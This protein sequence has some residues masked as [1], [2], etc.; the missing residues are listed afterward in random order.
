MSR[1]ADPEL[2]TTGPYQWIRH[3]IYSGILLGLAGT[4]IAVSA[5]WLIAV[6]ITGA[7]F[8]VSAVVE[9]RTMAKLFP[10][11]YPPYRR[12]TKM[13]IPFLL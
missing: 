6:A 9:E 10:A 5:Y 3:P 8:L 13:L 12:V 2:V 1:R 11:A 4:A 7:Y